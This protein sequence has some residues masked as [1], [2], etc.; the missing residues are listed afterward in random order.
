[1]R[2]RSTTEPATMAAML[3]ERGF[4]PCRCGAAR[5]RTAGP[6]GCGRRGCSDLERGTPLVTNKM[7]VAKDAPSKPRAGK[8]AEDALANLMAGPYIVVPF[9]AWI[10][11]PQTGPEVIVREYEWGIGLEPR[12][13][14]RC[15]FLHLTSATMVEIEGGAHGVQRQRKHDVLRD[16]LAQQAGYRILRVLPE[17]VADGSALALVRQAVGGTK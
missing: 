13:R 10:L 1:M 4:V 11:A 8:A 12:R 5:K 6:W 16:Q 7:P 9:K 15:D 17:Q 2:D 14:F 3:T